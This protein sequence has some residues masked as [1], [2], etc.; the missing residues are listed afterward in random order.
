LNGLGLD[1]TNGGRLKVFLW[2]EID[3]M[4][5]IY[6]FDVDVQVRSDTGDD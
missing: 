2:D 4:D 3:L 6:K 5:P 1:F